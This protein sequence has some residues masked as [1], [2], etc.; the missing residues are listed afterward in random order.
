MKSNNNQNDMPVNMVDK[1][2]H[3]NIMQYS[4]INKNQFDYNQTI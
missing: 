1:N 2:N 4:K 3:H